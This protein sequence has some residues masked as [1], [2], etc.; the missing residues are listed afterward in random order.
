MLK[1]KKDGKQKQGP[2]MT[3]LN[4]KVNNLTK[5]ISAKIELEP[6]DG[7][8]ENKHTSF[9]KFCENEQYTNFQPLEIGERVTIFTTKEEEVTGD[10]TEINTD[11][12]NYLSIKKDDDE[13][14][15]VKFYE[16]FS[17]VKIKKDEVATASGDIAGVPLRVMLDKKTG[18]TWIGKI[19]GPVPDLTKGKKRKLLNVM[20][21]I[22]YQ[23]TWEVPG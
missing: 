19:E 16:I 21:P 15:P 14:V 17:I 9:K 4:Q 10:V 18:K 5:K 22:R 23:Y 6:S 8:K 12:I 2:F 7:L 1:E 13:V 3:K 20:D 11:K